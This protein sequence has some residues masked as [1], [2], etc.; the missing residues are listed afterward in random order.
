M[1]HRKALIL[2]G[3]GVLLCATLVV[4]L[5]AFFALTNRPKG[6]QSGDSP[7][8]TAYNYL[9]A[10]VKKDYR[11]AYG[12]L[13]PTLPQYP[14]DLDIFIRDL[15]QHNLLPVYELDPCVYIEGAEVKS[16]QAEVKL[17]VQY[18]DPCLRSWWLEIQNL[19]QTPGQ[20]RLEQVEGSWK[21]VD[22]DDWFFYYGCWADSSECK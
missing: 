22:A 3:I 11:R 18:Y 21:I 7:E 15:E 17:R 1:Y 8:A 19:T 5:V 10:L 4:G 2:I 6:Y 9:M 12:Y 14:E 16:D 20:M 13:S